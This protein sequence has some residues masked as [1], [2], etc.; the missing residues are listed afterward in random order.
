[1]RVPAGQERGRA[2]PASPAHG[3]GEVGR[4]PAGGRRAGEALG[5]RRRAARAL[6]AGP[7]VLPEA[8]LPTAG[9]GSASGRPRGLSCARSSGSRAAPPP[10]RRLPGPSGRARA[11]AAAAAACARRR[12]GKMNPVCTSAPLN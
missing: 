3:Q 9:R 8:E 5:S 10:P 11:A 7:S 1:M 6:A 4:G 12:S 2:P